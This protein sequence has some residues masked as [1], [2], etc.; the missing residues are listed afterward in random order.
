MKIYTKTGDAGTTALLGG[1]RVPKSHIRIDAYGSVDELNAYMGLLRDQEI[2]LRRA[3]FLKK[4]QETL[5]VTGASLAT[6]PGKE[7]VKK[8]DILPDDITALEN[9][10]DVMEGQLNPLRRFILPGGH[11]V[12]SFCHIARTVCR[13]SERCVVLLHEQE[14]VEEIIIKYLNRLSDYLFVLGRLVAKE[15]GVEEVTWEPR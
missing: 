10:I 13:R 9:E 1:A 7:N 14:E 6:S 15:L 12:V 3:A 2:N 11:Q 4:I 8:P 5:F